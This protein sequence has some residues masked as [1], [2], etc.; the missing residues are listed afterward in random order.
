MSGTD[1]LQLGLVLYVLCV[2]MMAMIMH[3]AD[4]RSRI[5][6]QHVRRSVG[7]IMLI[8]A[9]ESLVIII[10]VL[11]YVFVRA[12]GHDIAV[13]AGFDGDAGDEQ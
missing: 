5:Q 3:H 9:P 1:W 10:I 8:L 13:Y 11:L 6:Q 4:F 12:M 7:A 2:A